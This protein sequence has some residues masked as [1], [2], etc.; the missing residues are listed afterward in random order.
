MSSDEVSGVNRLCFNVKP[1]KETE[2]TMCICCIHGSNAY[3]VVVRV[4]T[5]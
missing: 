3:N 4:K 5:M 1:H 2:E